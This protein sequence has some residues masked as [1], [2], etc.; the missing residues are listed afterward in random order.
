MEKLYSITFFKK[1]ETEIYKVVNIFATSE[2]EA[3]ELVITLDNE[4]EDYEGLEDL[5]YCFNN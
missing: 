1:W 5:E 3:Y 2:E 4:S